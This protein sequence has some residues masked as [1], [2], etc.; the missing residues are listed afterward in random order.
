MKDKSALRDRFTKTSK[1]RS[2]LVNDVLNLNKKPQLKKPSRTEPALQIS[3]FNLVK[4]ITGTQG[5][6][7]V[8]DLTKV[9][10]KR[11]KHVEIGN[12][13]SK[14]QHDTKT[15]PKPLEK[16]R[17]DRIRRTVAFEGV[18]KQ[19]DR[20]DAVVTSNRASNQLSF[21]LPNVKLED[22]KNFTEFRLKT[23]L[24]KELEELEP[25]VEIFN[26]ENEP[27]YSLTMQE[28]I[29]RRK[30]M[31]KVRAVQSY[32]EAKARRQSKIKS[33]KYHRIQRREKIKQ[34]MKEFELLQKTNPEEALKKLE[35]IEKVRAME[36][37]D[38]RHRSTGKWAR[39]KQVQAK[40]DK[41]SRQALAQQLTLSRELT[42]K[43]KVDES[44]SEPEEEIKVDTGNANRNNPWTDLNKTPNEIEEFVS[45]YRKFWENKDKEIEE[46]S[47]DDDKN[48]SSFDQ[49]KITNNDFVEAN[50][51]KDHD[52]AEDNPKLQIKKQNVKEEN[53]FQQKKSMKRG[54]KHTSRKIKVGTSNWEIDCVGESGDDN[55]ITT[56]D[57]KIDLKKKLRKKY[58][59]FKKELQQEETNNK[60]KQ[61]TRKKKLQVKPIKNVSALKLHVIPTR[62]VVKEPLLESYGNI[63]QKDK[64]GLDALETILK[65]NEPVTK[66]LHKNT[67][68][69]D[70]ND[71]AKV[72]PISLNTEVPDLLAVD[73]D[74]EEENAD[75]NVDML[76]A[77]KDDD[78]I[79]EFEKD[80][81]AEIDKDKPKDINLT[82]PGWGSWGGTGIKLSKRKRGRF[83]VKFPKKFKRRDDNKG[84]LIINEKANKNIKPHMVSEVPFPFKKTKDF[85]ASVRAPIG[86]TFVPETAFRK[87]IRPPVLTKMGTVIEPMTEDI[88]LKKKK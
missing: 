7:H 46:F 39:N 16:S 38:L 10:K 2:Q 19:L 40:Y 67:A 79:A 20:W 77:F 43:L 52:I 58:E 59:T 15:L 84:N 33:K 62:P 45:G 14:A 88:L 86:N 5:V 37:A 42:Q 17:A 60:S 32:K 61:A 47:K 8:N 85:E 48:V 22:N 24:Q 57:I 30:E 51:N 28:M 54:S 13:V 4:S 44:E 50:I 26:L 76:E 80:K 63:L 64:N 70:P 78:I 34:Q 31:A 25:K 87:M 35:E 21:P 73:L 41:E 3:E 83:I 36:R 53:N 23:D 69:I 74:D 29:E 18:K 11:A 9:L 71:I 27:K 55:E 1:K 68:N 72:K 6:V 56:R 65:S 12:K 75:Q 66:E 49:H 82:L 81:R